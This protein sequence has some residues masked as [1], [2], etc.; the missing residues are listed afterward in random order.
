MATE[1]LRMVLDR[2]TLGELLER[3]QALE[4]GIYPVPEDSHRYLSRVK[5]ARD[6]KNKVEVNLG[7]DKQQLKRVKQ[8]VQPN[9]NG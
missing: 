9:F 8:R 5:A 4:A 3:D 7:P 2:S 1:A 6:G